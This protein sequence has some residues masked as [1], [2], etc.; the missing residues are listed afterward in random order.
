MIASNCG[1]CGG[2]NTVDCTGACMLCGDAI[3]VCSNVRLDNPMIEMDLLG[4][5]REEVIKTIVAVDLL[6]DYGS[7]TH[8]PRDEAERIADALL[9]AAFLRRS[10]I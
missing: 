10:K 2:H 8:V 9:E 1:K 4:L 5:T 6:G 7:I 3:G